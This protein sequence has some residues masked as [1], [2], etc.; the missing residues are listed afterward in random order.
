MVGTPP[1]PRARF[2]DHPEPTWFNQPAIGRLTVTSQRDIRPFRTCNTEL[3]YTEQIKPWG[4]PDVAHPSETERARA[5]GPRTLIGPFERDPAIRLRADWI[6][7][8]QPA[9]KPVRIYSADSC[10]YRDNAIKVL[11]YGDYFN[12]HRQQ[13]EAKA[14]DPTDSKRCHPWTS[15]EIQP[16]HLTTTEQRRVGKES[17]RLTGEKAPIDSANDPVPD[18]GPIERHCRAC[19]QPV[20][21]RRK[22]CSEACRKRS[23]RDAKRAAVDVQ[24]LTS[25]T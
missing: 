8:D 10:E 13:P 12:R 21:G 25:V 11:S 14:L 1:T 6:D 7:R 3:P 19:A 2:L 16:S 18:C 20:S 17:N 5:D 4:F 23:G 15:G 22:W 24:R 9:R